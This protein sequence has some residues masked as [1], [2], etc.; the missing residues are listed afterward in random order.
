MVRW[1]RY[2]GMVDCT[3]IHYKHHHGHSH[4][5]SHT[6]KL[7]TQSYEYDLPG[8]SHARKLR[9]ALL[10]SAVA[11]GA[12]AIGPIAPT[13]RAIAAPPV[14]MN[15]GREAAAYCMCERHPNHRAHTGGG[16][17]GVGE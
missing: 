5:H 16:P 9:S 12:V 6:R 17:G 14:G 4:K 3:G 2:L 8:R 11:A 10:Y 1:Y 15:G 7:E 13:P